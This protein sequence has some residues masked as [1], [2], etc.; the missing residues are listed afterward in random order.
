VASGEISPEQAAEAVAATDARVTPSMLE[1]G[2]S[3]GGEPPAGT[4]PPARTEPSST[5]SPSS[6]PPA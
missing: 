6:E 4:E 3:A 2:G 1:T 5:E